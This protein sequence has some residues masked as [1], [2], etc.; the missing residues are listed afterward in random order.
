[1]QRWDSHAHVIGDPRLLP[2]ANGRGYTP[3]PAPLES[4]LA[5][6]DR[7]ELAHG[8][9]V[10]P[11]VYGDDHRCLID[12]LN[13]AGGRLFGI[14]VPS[15]DATRADLEALHQ[16][17]IRGVRCNLIN[18]GG[19]AIAAVMSWSDVLRALGWHV[20]AQVRLAAVPETVKH[21]R[22]LGVPVVIDHMGRP[23]PAELDPES[24]GAKAL[25]DL[26]RTGDCYVKLSAPYRASAVGPPWRD[27]SPL[28]RALVAANPAHCLWGSDWPHTDMPTVVNTNDVVDALAEWCPDET[29]RTLVTSS[30]ARL[31][32]E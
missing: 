32:V 5:M 27:V 29:S 10:Q 11:S 22:G 21:L 20:E 3:Q 28:A 19:L 17:G 13:R 4:Y 25:I 8:V 18:P 1:M 26:V 12:A 6:L 15:P 31:F 16:H 23:A 14:A 7:H 9:L 24:D 30:A 2:F